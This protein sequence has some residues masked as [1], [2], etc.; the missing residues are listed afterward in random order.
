VRAELSATDVAVLHRRTEGWIVGLQLAALSIQGREDVQRAVESFA[1]SQRHILDYLLDEVFRQQTADTQGFLLQTAIL[2]RL[3]AALC[4]AVTERPGSQQVLQALEQ[5]NLFIIPLDESR[6]WYRY[7][8]LFADLLRHRLQMLRGQDVLP[9][10]VRASTWYEQNGFPADAVQHALAAQD[11]ERAGRLIHA[12][13]GALLRRGE[14]ATL[15]GWFARLPPHIVRAQPLLCLDHGWPLLLAGQLDAAESLLDCAAQAASD[16][17]GLLGEVAAA[18]V[19]LARAKG[20]TRRSVEMAQKALSLLPEND[21]GTRGMVA[22]NL[23]LVYWH[24]GCMAEAEEVLREAQR[25]ALGSGND[26]VRVTSQL[27]LGRV[28]AV[29]GELR[30]A[31]NACQ[32]TLTEVGQ[33]PILTMAHLDLCA[34]HY[35]WNEL[36]RAAE[37]LRHGI[38]S[39]E[40]SGNAEFLLAAHLTQSRLASALGDHS[41]ALR[42]VQECHRLALAGNLPVHTVSRIASGAVEAALA[43]GDVALAETWE[44]QTAQDADAHPFYRYLGLARARLWIAQGERQAA[45]QELQRCFETASRAGWGYG[46]IAVLVL[47]SLAAETRQAALE[48]LTHALQRAQPEGFIRTFADAGAAL[49]PLLQEAA[50]R[51]VAPEYVGR[52]LATFRHKS[53]TIAPDMSTLA[54]PLSEREPGVLRL[55]AAGLSNR[56]IARKLIISLGTAKTHV[57]NICGKLDAR[58]RAH[59]VVRAQELHLI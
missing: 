38:E 11:W 53:A 33:Y 28:R 17:P 13:A 43:Q 9:L 57:H 49:T 54:E 55:L 21:L 27:F 15:L 26:Y 19:Y 3:T 1:G 52:I 5:A 39:A 2:D 58:N 44:R 14:V 24:A 29:R 42:A 6:S 8:H 34:L 4:D 45:S 20:D 7:H 46:L 40:R 35:E 37:C 51:G 18:Q 48:F 47:Q 59:A 25:A 31:A 10:H 32:T 16:E 23:G 50:Q 56:E 41:G 36:E 30:L 12:A 22:M